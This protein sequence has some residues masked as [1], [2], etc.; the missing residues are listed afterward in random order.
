MKYIKKFIVEAEQWN[1]FGD[2][3]INQHFMKGSKVPCLVCSNALGVHGMLNTGRK[4]CPGDWVVTEGNGNIL[5]VSDIMFHKIH[6][7]EYITK[8]ELKELALELLKKYEHAENF[9]ICETSSDS[10]ADMVKLKDE[11]KIYRG[12]IN[13]RFI[14]AD[15]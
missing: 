4:V 9:V 2:A 13:K 8:D 7:K 15:S 12:R 14:H 1:K 6:E 3:G 5:V 11:C 10:Y